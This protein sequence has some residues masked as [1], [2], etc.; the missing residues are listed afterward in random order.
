MKKL[1]ILTP[2]LFA[3]LGCSTLQ[4]FLFPD[5]LDKDVEVAWEKEL[6]MQVNE[7]V[8][9]GTAV[10]P[11][12]EK[13]LIYIFPPYKEIS[14]LQW[15]TCHRGG[16]AKNAVQ[17]GR[18]PWSKKESYFKLEIKPRDIERERA[19]SLKFEALDKSQKAMAFGMI[20][21]PD[22]RPWFNVPGTVECN[23]K[24]E[25][26]FDGTSLCQAPAGAITRISFSGEIY[27]DETPN[28]D[29]PPFK[30]IRTGVF[31][32]LM[33]KNECI[34]NFKKP[35]EHESGRLRSH[36]LITFGYEKTPP[37]EDY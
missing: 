21:F 25:V 3:V 16:A 5:K 27:M 10:V 19:C 29:C 12:A 6:R 20:A 37:Q 4:G 23:G 14:R 22:L 35:Q 31:E 8:Y 11:E 30:E 36:K 28:A 2:L 1:W 17:Y 33:P 7:S 32:F 34:Y 15:R 26:Y 24:V 13:Y 18:W 9:Y